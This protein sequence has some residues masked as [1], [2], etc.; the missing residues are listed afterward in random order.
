MTSLRVFLLPLGETDLKLLAWLGEPLQ[1]RLGS[2]FSVSSPILLPKSGLNTQRNQYNSRVILNWLRSN[3]FS[4]PLLAVTDVDLYSPSLN[5]VFGEAELG[6]EVAIISLA[7][8]NPTFYGLPFNELLLRD[9]ALKEAT[10]ELGHLFGLRHCPNQ[11]CV[12]HF[13]NTLTDT[14][15]KNSIFCKQCKKRLRSLKHT[16]N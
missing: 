14:D 10:H 12:M 15:R 8:L 1:E 13:S 3:Q 2:Q 4:F 9:R 11:Q 7:R 5:F 16:P 6:G